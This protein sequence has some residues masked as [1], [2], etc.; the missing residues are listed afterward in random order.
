MAPGVEIRGHA[1]AN[2]DPGDHQRGEADQGEEFAH[3]AHEAIG[4]RRG[5][6]GGAEV[7]ACFGEAGFERLLHRLG[8]LPAGEGDTGLGLIHRARRDQSGADRQILGSDHRGAELETLAELVGLVGDDAAD[9]ERLRPDGDGVPGGD[10]EPVGCNL[11]EPDFIRRRSAHRTSVLQREFAIE[12]IGGIDR[13]QP[14]RDRLIACPRH[15][16]H[17]IAARQL[18]IF[19][20]RRAFLWV[21]AA[22]PQFDLEIAAKQGLPARRD[23]LLDRCGQRT[24]RGQRSGAQEQADQQQAQATEARVEVAPRDPPGGRPVHA[25]AADASVSVRVLVRVSVAMR[26]SARVI[27][28]AHFSASSGSWVMTRSVAPVSARRAKSRSTIS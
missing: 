5:A 13:L 23:F 27:T 4:A 2:S 25:R 8:I 1:T 17:A 7:E 14:D 11:T 18:A 24:D 15:R 21:Q 12:R 26:P 10:A 22:L 9:G 20:K 19:G 6:V 3:P 16:L 28:R